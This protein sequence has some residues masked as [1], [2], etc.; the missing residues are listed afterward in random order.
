ML[1]IWANEAKLAASKLRSK[2]LAICISRP[3]QERASKV[4]GPRMDSRK[5]ICYA[6]NENL[7][8]E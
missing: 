1:V 8:Y 7:S 2:Q 4:V 3:K 6:T 5:L